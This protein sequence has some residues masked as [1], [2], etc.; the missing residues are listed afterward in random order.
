MT[1][2][3]EFKWPALESDP[4]IFN[5][6]FHEV[7]LPEFLGFQ[8]VMTM[9][10]NEIE[11]LYGGFPCFGVIATIRRPK[12]K[13]YN[14]QNLIEE[15]DVNYFMKQTGQLDNACGLIAGLH[16]LGNSITV[17]D[18]STGE[19]I[20]SKFF[21]K[22]A[23]LNPLQKADLL[24]NFDELKL[25]HKIFASQGQTEVPTTESTSKPVVHHFI[26]FIN[27]NNK[28]IE[29]DGTLPG[30]I[31]IKK[32]TEAEDCL[33]SSVNELRERLQLGVIG[34]DMSMFFLTYC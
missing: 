31:V 18:L 16:L 19:S 11:S 24:N 32:D 20:L 4:E 30:P 7:G 23:D 1:E 2:E 25:K 9:D 17:Q 33:K 34:E 28:L 14:E 13:Y 15:K 10:P 8:E 21:S 3:F 26:S 6:Y 12:G 5:K 22:A 29:F 27:I